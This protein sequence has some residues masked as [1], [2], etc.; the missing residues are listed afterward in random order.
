MTDLEAIARVQKMRDNLSGPANQALRADRDALSR[1]LEMA[2]TQ[3]ARMER[4][5]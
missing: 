3:R 5:K 1:V 4:L 2:E